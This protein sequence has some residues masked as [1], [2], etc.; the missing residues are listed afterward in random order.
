MLDTAPSKKRRTVR[1]CLDD[2]ASTSPAPDGRC[3]GEAL[4]SSSA[5]GPVLSPCAAADVTAQGTG[6]STSLCPS[7]LQTRGG[8]PV[9]GEAHVSDNFL[10]APRRG[11]FSPGVGEDAPAPKRAR[12]CPNLGVD[13]PGGDSTDDDVHGGSTLGERS[14]RPE[15]KWG[16]RKR[17]PLP[18]ATAARKSAQRRA[19]RTLQRRLAKEREEAFKRVGTPPPPRRPQPVAAPDRIASLWARVLARAGVGNDVGTSARI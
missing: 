4:S 15:G 3:L 6:P 8:A 12:T 16:R 7:T 5:S 2:S 19:T 13:P 17:H 18:F 14:R 9:V 10:V 11:S 1:F